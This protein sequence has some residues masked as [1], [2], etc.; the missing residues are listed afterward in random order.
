MGRVRMR[1]AV[2]MELMKKEVAGVL[3]CVCI[4][5]SDLGQ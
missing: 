4:Q 5:Y 2:L 3:V 1:M